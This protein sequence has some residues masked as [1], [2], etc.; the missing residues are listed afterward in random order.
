MPIKNAIS[1]F[2]GAGGDTCGLERAGFKV[3]AYN[4]FNEFA[5]LTHQK[6]HPDSQLIVNPINQNNDITKIDDSVFIQYA[7][8]IDLIFAGFPC[9]GFSHAG[10][11]KNK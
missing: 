9:Q 10:K 3:V 8:K 1:L 4:E 6:E 11:K 2:S 7:D 5:I